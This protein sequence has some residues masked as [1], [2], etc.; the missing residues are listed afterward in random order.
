MFNSSPTPVLGFEEHTQ[1]CPSLSEGVGSAP[2][3]PCSSQI[4]RL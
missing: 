2:L 3:G 1:L 4:G